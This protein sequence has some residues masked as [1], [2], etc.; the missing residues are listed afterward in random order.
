MPGEIFCNRRAEIG[1]AFHRL[2]DRGNEFAGGGMLNEVSGGTGLACFCFLMPRTAAV[3]RIGIV[4]L[5]CVPFP[6][7]A[8]ISKL[9]LTSRKWIRCALIVAVRLALACLKRGGAGYEMHVLQGDNDGAI[10]SDG[11]LFAS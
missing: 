8:S 2:A 7:C 3:A 10:G 5:I 1:I 4:T 9:P 6:G 11:T